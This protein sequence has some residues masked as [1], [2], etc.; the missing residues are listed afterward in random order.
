MSLVLAIVFVALFGG[1]H[2][3]SFGAVLTLSV[4]W[5]VKWSLWLLTALVLLQAVLSWVNP[6]APIA[7]ALNALT[8][9]FL[10]PIR[11][12]VPLIGGVDLSPLVLILVVQVLLTLLQSILPDVLALAR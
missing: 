3:P 9:P 2:L 11:R 10:E 1:G 8:R 12:F 7:P 4:F 6:Y 5:L